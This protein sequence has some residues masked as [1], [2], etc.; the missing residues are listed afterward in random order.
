[1]NHLNT[2]YPLDTVSSTFASKNDK[3]SEKK[4]YLFMDLVKEIPKLEKVEL[5]DLNISDYHIFGANITWEK[6]KSSVIVAQRAYYVRFFVDKNNNIF[7]PEQY[8]YYDNNSNV[9]IQG[10]KF[11]IF[12]ANDKAKGLIELILKDVS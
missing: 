11:M 10:N 9:R 4:Y 3:L 1:M 8:P 7:L 2:N 6:K 12:H 5:E